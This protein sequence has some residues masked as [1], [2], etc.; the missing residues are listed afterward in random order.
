[1][2]PLPTALEN[3]VRLPGPA[4]VLKAIVGRARRGF[5]TESGS[6]STVALTEDE[7][8]QVAQLLGTPWE[9]SGKPVRLQDLAARLGEHG[10]SVRELAEASQGATIEPDSTQ[11]ERVADAA[12]RE[13]SAVS[14]VLATAGVDPSVIDQWLDDRGLPRPGTGDLLTLAEQVVDVLGH[15]SRS[16][17]RIWLAQLAADVFNDAHRLDANEPLGRATARLAA[18]THRL[19]RPQRAGRDWRTAWASIGITCDAVSSRVLALNLPLD[20]DSPATRQCNNTFGEPIWLT[21]RTLTSN[22][23][24][25]QPTTIFV[26]E[27]VTIAQ[28]A[29]DEL[30]SNCPPLVCTDGIA[31]GAA[32]DLLAGLS[33]TGCTIK[34][35]ADFDQAG[36]TIGDQIL[37]VAPDAQSWRYDAATYA[38]IC[39][40][41]RRPTTSR[42]LSEALGDLRALYASTRI[43]VHEERLLGNLLADLAAAAQAG[44]SVSDA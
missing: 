44:C 31:S 24:V 16:G 7:R 2:R 6:L 18:I 21:L 38:T 33:A 28:A 43:P 12:Q 30:G 11:R 15:I 29:A 8:R 22:W 34:A 42:S 36:F 26:C 1:M 32:L 40:L 35:R 10:L 20:G 5:K 9:L 13:R 3:W 25:H 23:S 19:P 41:P 27:N 4:A 14:A 39:D 17:R 37:S